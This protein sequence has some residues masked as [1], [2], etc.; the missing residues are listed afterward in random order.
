MALE[1]LVIAPDKSG[2][3]LEDGPEV[4]STK[5][6]GGF[7]RY[8][9]DILN[10][11]FNVNMTWTLDDSEYRYLRTFFKAI[12]QS[13]ALPFK[14]D[15]LVDTAELVECIA[16]FVPKTFGLKSHTGLTYVVGATLECKKVDDTPVNPDYVYWYNAFNGIVFYYED[17]L[18]TIVN[19]R[20]PQHLPGV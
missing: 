20:L 4:L 6:D 19:I 15:L 11:A 10:A 14:I 8:R 16:Y 5:L 2:Y 3:S 1:K 13:G 17:L 18:N 7:S 12:T 9:K